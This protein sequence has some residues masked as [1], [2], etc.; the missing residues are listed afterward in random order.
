[1]LTWVEGTSED[2]P[3]TGYKLYSDLG[4]PGNSYLIYDG[5]GITQVLEYFDTGLEPGVKYTYTLEVLNF[6][7][8]SVKSPETSRSA[9]E[10]PQ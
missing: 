1:M 7:G 3:V 4:F 2:I 10:V 5:S 6:N 8:A 9:C